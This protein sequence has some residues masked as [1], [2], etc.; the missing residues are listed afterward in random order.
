MKRKKVLRRWIRLSFLWARWAFVVF[1]VA[2]CTLR[3]T[4][5]TPQEQETGSEPNV[6][7]A[8]TLGESMYRQ[9]IPYQ[10]TRG[11]PTW[12]AFSSRVDLTRFELGLMELSRNAFPPERYLYQEGQVLSA[13]EISDWLQPYDAEKAPLGLNDAA[14]LSNGNVFALFWEQDYLELSSQALAGVTVGMVVN[15]TVR[16]QPKSAPGTASGADSQSRNLTPEELEAYARAAGE[17]IGARL[18][19]RG[20][21]GPIVLAA[22]LAQPARS[23][24][25]LVPGHFFLYGELAK[26]QKSGIRWKPIEERYV[27]L[28]ARTPDENDKRVALLFD[29]FNQKL[30]KAFP[31]YTGIVGLARFDGERLLEL[32]I[33]VTA[34]YRSKGEVLGIAQYAAAL[35]EEIFPS[36]TDIEVYVQSIDRPQALYVRP[37][38]G[39]PFLHVFRNQ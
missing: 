15:P 1:T 22:Y 39:E 28:P 20:V 14:F 32:S 19:E 21:E 36:G 33:T 12:N 16:E 23:E 11:L 34:T 18:R 5:A 10:P 2:G 31:Q 35:V 29:D 30:Q 26:G 24:R 38:A 13:E 6:T 25:V 4:P 7:P 17:K 37:A 9:P 3:P 27:L 8:F